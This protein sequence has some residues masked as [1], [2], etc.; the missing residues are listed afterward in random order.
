MKYLIKLKNPKK[1]T[2]K[3]DANNKEQALHFFEEQ[4]LIVNHEKE[5]TFLEENK[6]EELNE[7]SPKYLIE[8]YRWFDKVNGNIYHTVVITDIKTG[9]VIYKSPHVVY[10]YGQQWKYT[11]YDELV[12]LNLAKKEDIHNHDLNGKRFI[13]RESDVTRKKDLF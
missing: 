11:A 1:D 9:N 13:Y 6:K 2:Y 8:G 4:D 10:G 5:N 3:I 12:K 7:N